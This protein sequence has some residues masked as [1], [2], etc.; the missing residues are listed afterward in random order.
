MTNCAKTIV[1]I[2]FFFFI[3]EYILGLV[4]CRLSLLA[5][6]LVEAKILQ[7][8]SSENDT[9]TKRSITHN[10]KVMFTLCD[11]TLSSTIH[12]IVNGYILKKVK[13]N[14]EDLSPLMI[15]K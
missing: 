4:Q 7:F 10:V 15:L 3:S 1:R 6:F 12:K 13:K 5:Q 2:V 11:A 9:A 8:L 14:M